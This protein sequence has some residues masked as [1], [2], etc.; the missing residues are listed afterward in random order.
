ME[1]YVWIWTLKGQGKGAEFGKVMINFLEVPP[2]QAY[3]PSFKYLF[4]IIQRSG[5]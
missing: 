5:Y 4:N 1:I 2:P 3:K